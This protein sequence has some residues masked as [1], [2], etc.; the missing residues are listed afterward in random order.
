MVRVSGDLVFFLF[1][2]DTNLFAEGSDPVEL[3]E[4]LSLTDRLTLNLK[5]TEYV[6]FAGPRPP[7][8]PPGGLVIGGEQIRREEGVRLLGVWID[9]GLK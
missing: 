1:A 9:V 6:Y 4:R 3:F 8:L 7:E 5:K 2:D